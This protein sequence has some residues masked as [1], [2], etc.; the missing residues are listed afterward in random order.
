MLKVKSRIYFLTP[1]EG[2]LQK[3]PF[4]GM[5][6]SFFIGGK[7]ITSELTFVNKN[8]EYTLGCQYP[9]E[10]T[11]PYG[12]L[13]ADEINEGQKFRLQIGGQLVARGEVEVI[14]H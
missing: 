5:R 12:E 7:L 11:L 4:N 8:D 13:Y 14:I 10:I 1:E 9:V 2:G 6:P 3:P